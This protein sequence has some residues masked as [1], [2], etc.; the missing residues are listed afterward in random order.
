MCSSSS[1]YIE[2]ASAGNEIPTQ[3]RPHLSQAYVLCSRLGSHSSMPLCR[4]EIQVSALQTWLISELGG[5]R[6]LQHIPCR[7]V[8]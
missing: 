7:D 3:W 6:T 4:W 1:R 2:C 8:L 5:G